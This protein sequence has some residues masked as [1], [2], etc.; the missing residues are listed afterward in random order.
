MTDLVTEEDSTSNFQLKN[1][2]VLEGVG[3][4]KSDD[5]IVFP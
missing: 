5:D 3:T 4:I 2:E 1:S